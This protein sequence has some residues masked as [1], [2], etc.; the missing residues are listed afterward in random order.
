MA[1]QTVI[2]NVW[3]MMVRT[4]NVQDERYREAIENHAIAEW[5]NIRRIPDYSQHLL[6]SVHDRLN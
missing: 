5:E 4:C 6:D 1:K 2:E 3:A